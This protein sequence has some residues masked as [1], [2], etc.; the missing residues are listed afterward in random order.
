MVT[1][2]PTTR[3][4]T[5]NEIVNDEA[6]VVVKLLPLRCIIEQKA[7]RFTRAFFNYSNDDEV[8]KNGTDSLPPGL[9]AIPPPLFRSF[10]FKPFKVKVDYC[11]EKIDTKA[12]RDGAFIELINLSP[13]DGMVLTLDNVE[14]ENVV[15]LGDVLSLAVRRWI[16]DVASTQMYKFLTSTRYLEPIAHVGIASADVFVLP[17]EA[18]QNG[19]S[20]TKA[21][22]AGFKSLSDA[23]AYEACTTSSR[24]AQFLADQVAK[25]SSLCPSEPGMPLPPRPLT[26]PR[27][28][29]DT[30]PHAVESLSRG[31][32]TA[33]YKVVIVP[34]REYRRRGARGAATSVLRGIPVAIA[35]PTS[36]TAEALSYAL[37]GVRNQL[38]PDIRRE[39]ESLQRGL[40]WGS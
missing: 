3:V 2:H 24:A 27:D 12:L 32:Q 10:R 30:A 23:V 25:L 28:L 18:L 14:V 33:G 22:R 39:E 37:M 31:F 1:W 4:T 34:Y 6:E 26:T 17:W 13:I 19:E 35:A 11:P 5:D 15:G 7:V 40:H 16:E 29:F 21:L 36:G 8:T 38:R 9:H 20:F